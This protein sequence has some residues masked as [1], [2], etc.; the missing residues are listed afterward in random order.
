MRQSAMHI[1]RANPDDAVV[2]TDIAFAAKRHWGYPEKWI[3]GWHDVLTI[4][5]EF[6]ASHETYVATLDDRKVGFYALSRQGD[7]FDLRKSTCKRKP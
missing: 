2:L 6:I 7:R 3:E 1:A 4:S 5:P